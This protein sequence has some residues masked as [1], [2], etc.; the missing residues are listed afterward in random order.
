[1]ANTSNKDKLANERNSNNSNKRYK[2]H[3]RGR[4]PQG[5]NDKIA[6]K[7]RDRY[8]EN[9][10]TNVAEPALGNSPDWYKFND[11][12][13]GSATN[14]QFFN[15]I[16][17]IE[18]D[19]Q[20]H[21]G[22]IYKI[23]P[24]LM[25]F[26]F[27]PT[28]GMTN[29]PGNA[30]INIQAVA[31]KQFVQANI[32]QKV[33]FEPAD[34][35][36]Q[37]GAMDSIFMMYYWAQRLYGVYRVRSVYNITMPNVYFKSMGLDPDNMEVD[38]TWPQ[39]LFELNTIAVKL[40][41]FVIPADLKIFARHLQLVSN[42]YTDAPGGKSQQYIFNPAGLWKYVLNG[43]AGHQGGALRFEVLPDFAH[44]A[45][46]ER[47]LAG[48]IKM[49]NDLIDPIYNDKTIRDMNQY[50]LKVYGADKQIMVHQLSEN[51][52][53]LP[54][55]VPEILPQIHN[56]D[57][58]GDL[59]YFGETHLTNMYLQDSTGFIHWTP[60]VIDKQT[61]AW[62][63]TYTDKVLDMPNLDPSSDD[64]A[65]ASRLM[66]CGHGE[67]KNGHVITYIDAYGSEIIN[68]AT[69]YAGN[70]GY[71]D[72]FKYTGIPYN[73]V[74]SDNNYPKYT[75]S[76]MSSLCRWMAFGW[77]PMLRFTNEWQVIEGGGP[78]EPDTYRVDTTWYDI[79]ADESNLAYFDAKVIRNLHRACLM[80]QLYV[81]SY[82]PMGAER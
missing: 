7:T 47:N 2:Y 71:E 52:Q 39:F 40:A 25:S 50:F 26:R 81:P 76:F 43:E 49:L 23:T 73:P 42:I 3:K 12:M 16:G 82:F 8:P 61:G 70:G 57:I 28:L 32:T 33:D 51:Y 1:M 53:V 59:N 60:A 44:A 74:V 20:M 66:V 21:D 45:E 78:F 58:V 46:G 10:R 17:E 31:F 11:T 65:V 19:T 13:L 55:Y 9:K 29:E 4:K 69:V 67:E 62:R 15:V 63:G 64:I 30:P 6:S 22:H 56:M 38:M 14:L 77:G 5:G 48:V 24:T 36:V 37:L 34:V 68:S 72:V 79:L 35:A 41:T 54:V 80:G 27:T 75:A 18:K